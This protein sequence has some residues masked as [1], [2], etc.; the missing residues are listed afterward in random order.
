MKST[1]IYHSGYA[2][3]LF[4]LLSATNVSSSPVVK[5][6]MLPLECTAENGGYFIPPNQV[7]GLEAVK[8]CQSMGG[9]LVDVN[10]ENVNELTE[11][12]TRCIGGNK[13]VRIQTWDTNG[14]GIY[15]LV[16]HTGV[17]A[18]AGT[19]GTARANEALYAL[20]QTGAPQI[21]FPPPVNGPNI[22][23]GMDSSQP[24]DSEDC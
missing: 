7:R 24:I 1:I 18:G 20:C 15:D 3:I 14:F 8:Y 21:P 2:A 12:V 6:Q 17:Q 10:N 5:R 9:K 13:N 4:L 19:V 16:L 11:I 22:Y 23:P